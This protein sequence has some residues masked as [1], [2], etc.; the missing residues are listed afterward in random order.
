MNNKNKDFFTVKEMANL[1]GVSRIT[2]FNRIKKGQ[3]IATKIGRDYLISAG[4]LGFILKKELTDSV[5]KEIDKAV[6]K[7]IKQ[8]G[9]TLRKL[10]KE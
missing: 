8:Y 7:T 9:E 5:K 6:D 1:L 10:G 4:Q 2:V 3:I